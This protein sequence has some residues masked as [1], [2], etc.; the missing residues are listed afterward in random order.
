MEINLDK[1]LVINF[2]D[3]SWLPFIFIMVTTLRMCIAFPDLEMQALSYAFLGMELLSFAVMSFFYIKN[4]FA[5]YY[6]ALAAFFHILLLSVTIVFGMDIKN[7]FYWGCECMLIAMVMEYYKD[8][9]HVVLLSFTIAFSLCAYLNLLH[10]ITHPQLWFIEDEKSVGGYLLGNSYNQMGCRLI[11]AVISSY[12]CQKISKWWTVNTVFVIIASLIALMIV[13]SMTSLSCLILFTALC[14]IPFKQLLRLSTY[15]LFVFYFLFQI[16]VCFDGRGLENNEYATY[17]IVD[18]LDKDITFSNRTEMWD[19]ALKT[20]YESP[21]WGHGLVDGEWYLSHMNSTATGPHNLVFSI[22]IY[23][24]IMLFAVF[25]LLFWWSVKNILLSNDRYCILILTCIATYLIMCTME[26]YPYSFT[27]Y[28][29]ALAFY[30][31][32]AN[33]S[34]FVS[35]TELRTAI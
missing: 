25:G 30:F 27:L 4:G 10:I 24:G 3:S 26:V 28:L 5:S 20:F 19:S 35:S 14:M 34:S 7:C 22:L 13:R 15:G 2:N 18:V 11:C 8:R 12:L 29:L 23:G 31:P 1:L 6:I 21:I 33:S 17:V 9:F 32:Q 16:F